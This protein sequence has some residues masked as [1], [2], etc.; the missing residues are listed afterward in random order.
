MLERAIRRIVERGHSSQ[1]RAKPFVALE[2]E[3]IRRIGGMYLYISVY[4]YGYTTLT[5]RFSDDSFMYHTVIERYW[6]VLI[7]SIETRG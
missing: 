2:S 3:A 6:L 7:T 5:I 4:T 1:C